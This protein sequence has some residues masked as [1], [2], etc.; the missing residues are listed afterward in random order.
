MQLKFHLD[1]E[2]I[3][4]STV[5]KITQNDFGQGIEPL[6]QLLGP[7]VYQRTVLLNLAE[8]DYIDSSGV[9]WLLSSHKRFRE[10]GG[11][12]V[13]HSLSPMVSQILRVLKMEQVLQVAPDASSA[14]ALACGAS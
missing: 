13:I 11:S 6:A 7:D 9:G 10:A 5:G 14:R 1:G 4:V 12:L 8:S 2:C 3:S